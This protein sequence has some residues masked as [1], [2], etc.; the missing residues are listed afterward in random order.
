LRVTYATYWSLL[1][2]PLIMVVRAWQRFQM[3]RGKVDFSQQASDVAVPPALINQTLYGLVKLEEALLPS[4]P[5][6]SS[7][8]TVMNV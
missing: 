2:S 1:L 5:F 6:G 3:R 4:G 7:I 8:F